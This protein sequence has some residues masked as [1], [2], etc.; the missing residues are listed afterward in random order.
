[1]SSC[2][3][4]I[5]TM[6][7]AELAPSHRRGRRDRQRGFCCLSAAASGCESRSVSAVKCDLGSSTPLHKIWMG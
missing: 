1:M 7:T 5:S 2:K 3:G 6:A 4:V